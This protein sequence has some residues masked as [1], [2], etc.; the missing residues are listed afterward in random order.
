MNEQR[1]EETATGQSGQ[2]CA[3]LTYS[4][5]RHD[6]VLPRT[7]RHFPARNRCPSSHSCLVSCF[8]HCLVLLPFLPL[9]ECHYPEVLLSFP[10]GGYHEQIGPCPW[11]P[12]QH[13]VFQHPQQ[14]PLRQ[15]SWSEFQMLGQARRWVF[16]LPCKLVK[17]HISRDECLWDF[18]L[19]GSR[20]LGEL[21][22]P[23]Q[24][25]P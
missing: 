20:E 16:L 1:R 2:G 15:T 23:F 12:G 7:H 9:S 4:L 10:D 21:K 17:E 24:A 22:A 19:K 13:N 3:F 14:A 18:V 5:P 25:L 8:K 6:P 11:P